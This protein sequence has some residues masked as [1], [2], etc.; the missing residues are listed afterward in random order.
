MIRRGSAAA[1][2]RGIVPLS[3]PTP[4]TPLEETAARQGSATLAHRPGIQ[5]HLSGL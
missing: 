2:R 3:P 4:T 5:I 1:C